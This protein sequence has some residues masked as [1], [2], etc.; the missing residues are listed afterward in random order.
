[1]SNVIAERRNEEVLGSQNGQHTRNRRVF[2]PR[3]DVYETSETIV[4][5]TDMPG[6]NDN[7]IDITLEKNVLTLQGFTHQQVENLPLIYCESPEGNYRRVF[8]LS[9]EI[10]RDGIQATIKNGVLKIVLPKS[11]KAR[12]QKIKVK[13]E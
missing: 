2:I 5:L 6:V 4:V 9:E 7:S 10:E 13:A 3:A 8:T 12:A 1:M 11:A